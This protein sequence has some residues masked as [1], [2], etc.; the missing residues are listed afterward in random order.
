MNDVLLVSL[1]GK[2]NSI[3]NIYKSHVNLKIINTAL[4]MATNPKNLGLII[5]PKLTYCTHIHNIS[6]HTRKPQQMIKVLTATGW[7]KQKGTLMAT[8][9]AS[10]CLFH[11]VAS[12]IL[13]Q[14]EQTASHAECSIEN[15]HGMHTRHKRTTYAWRNTHTTHTRAP[16]VPR[17]TIQTENTNPLHPL[18]K[19]TTYFNPPRLKKHYFEQQPIHNKHSP[20]PPDSL[21]NRHKN[22]HAPYTYIYCL[23]ASS[24]KGQ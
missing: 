17:V 18:H 6:V 8:Y 24:H 9:K 12:C 1:V 15:C 19:H 10:R 16:T 3:N 4:H 7:G 22:K 2:G 20:R 21:D 14:H 13:N 5:E 11:M 23:H